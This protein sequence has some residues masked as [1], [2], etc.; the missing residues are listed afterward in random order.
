MTGRHRWA[1]LS[2]PD[3]W[4][5]GADVHSDPKRAGSLYLWD[6]KAVEV[7]APDQNALADPAVRRLVVLDQL[8]DRVAAEPADGGRF[9]HVQDHPVSRGGGLARDGGL[10]APG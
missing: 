7:Y 5:V 2:R 10:G 1:R 8:A 4:A 6:E 3:E 9:H